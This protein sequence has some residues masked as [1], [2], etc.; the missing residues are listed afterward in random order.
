ME[1]TPK[2]KAIELVDRFKSIEIEVASKYKGYGESCDYIEMQTFDAKECA[3]VAINRNIKMLNEFLNTMDG[4][5][6]E[7]KCAVMELIENEEEL[8]KEIEKL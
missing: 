6:H 2:E 5:M 3:M 7:A 8:K 1:L 4:W